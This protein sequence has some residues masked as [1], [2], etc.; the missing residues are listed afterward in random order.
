MP[1]L[2]PCIAQSIGLNG[3]L[4][5]AHELLMAELSRSIDSTQR[6][7]WAL[8]ILAE[9]AERR[10]RYEEAAQ[11]IGRALNADPSSAALRIQAADV[12]LRAG[13]PDRVTAILDPLPRFEPVVLRK[14]IAAQRV[15]AKDADM[16]AHEWRT[17]IARTS[18]SGSQR[19][20]AMW[21]LASCSCSDAP[22]RPY[23]TQSRTGSKARKSKTHAFSSRAASAAGRAHEALPAFRWIDALRVEDATMQRLRVEMS[24]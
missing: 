11:T 2:R 17:L 9:L 20:R 10:G 23:S 8:A 21:R 6:A 24:L 13:R 22:M 5:E 12:F 14:A 1:S 3:R 7:A 16:L 18:V 15:G 4:A 19:M